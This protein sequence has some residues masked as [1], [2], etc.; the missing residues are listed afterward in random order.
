V[1]VSREEP[2]VANKSI[3]VQEL[4]QSHLP[5]VHHPPYWA[6]LRVSSEEQKRRKTIDGQRNEV[7]AWAR[8]RGVKF[9]EMVEDDGSSGSTI[10]GRPKFAALLKA[11]EEGKIGTLVVTAPDR[12]TRAEE[13]DD[14]ARIWNALRRHRTLLVMTGFNEIDPLSETADMLLSN[15]FTLASMERKRMRAR[16]F[17]G[18][19]RAAESGR[20]PQGKAP[21][22]RHYDRETRKWSVVEAEAAIYRRIM[23]MCLEGRSTFAIPSILNQEGVPSPGGRSWSQSYVSELLR[24]RAALGEYTSLGH[25]FQIPPVIDLDTFEAV[26]KTLDAARA[27]HGP[28]SRHP[29]LF[30]G[31]MVCGACGSGVHVSTC[32]KPENRQQAYRCGNWH[33][34]HRTKPG[35]VVPPCAKL[36]HNADIVE[37]VVW[38]EVERVLGDPKLIHEAAGLGVDSK[39]KGA[40]EKEIT[41]IEKE[42]QSLDRQH[43]N[44]MRL[45]RKELASEDAL[46]RQLAEVGRQQKALADRLGVAKA[47]HDAAASINTVA[48]DLSARVK[49]IA[50]GIKAATMEQKRQLVMALFP[51]RAPFGLRLYPDGR[52]EA[53]GILP[54]PEQPPSPEGEPSEGNDASDQTRGARRWRGCSSRPPPC[55]SL[56]A[57]ERASRARSR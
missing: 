29:R 48:A 36:Q 41:S 28:R 7:D 53:V 16:S 4:G 20:L 26:N 6:Y 22:G 1:P 39:T 25:T 43:Q 17:G 30:S 45:Y 31:L 23:T 2:I 35:F 44:L 54:G 37:A 15:F 55:S 46:E 13:W 24:S 56:S 49:E 33:P 19:M 34:G 18:K 47:R 40:T 57:R 27:R 38:A 32:G 5:L 11:C 14:R 9:D 51:K 10:I 52:I 12:L 42:L 21:Y 50:H 3:I 8:L